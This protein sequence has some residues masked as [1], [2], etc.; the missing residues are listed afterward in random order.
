MKERQMEALNRTSRVKA[1]AP[2]RGIAKPACFR[3]K[4]AETLAVVGSLQASTLPNQPPTPTA[5]SFSGPAPSLMYPFT[6]TLQPRLQ[7]VRTG[8]PDT[9]F[10][11]SI[12]DRT[13]WR[14][15]SYCESSYR[16][17]LAYPWYLSPSCPARC[18]GRKD[19]MLQSRIL[20]RCQHRWLLG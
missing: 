3:W 5:V 13:D 20:L 10:N 4:Q 2:L 18:L 16:L 11:Q 9:L 7:R 8:L 14:L 12:A 17:R 19:P 1:A 15:Q 6:P